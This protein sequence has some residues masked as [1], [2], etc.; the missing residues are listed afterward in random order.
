MR[1]CNLRGCKATVEH[2]YAKVPHVRAKLDAAGVKPD[3]L[4]SLADIARFPFA[5]K[6][7]LRDTY[8]FGLFAVPREQLLRL[9]ASSGTTGKATVVGY[10]QADSISGPT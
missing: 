10:T 9:H 2:A 6:A 7:D 8:P 4:K 5:T 1:R 3:R